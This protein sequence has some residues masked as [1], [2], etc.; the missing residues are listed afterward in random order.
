MGTA[1]EQRG[2][3][4][5]KVLIQTVA[6][7]V[8]S[9]ARC[10]RKTGYNWTALASAW[11]N[12]RDAAPVQTTTSHAKHNAC[13]IDVHNGLIAKE[14]EGMGKRVLVT[15]GAGFVGSHLCERLLG[16]GHTV[17]CL[18]NYFTGTHHIAHLLTVHRF[19]AIR[20]D[21]TVTLNMEVDEIYNLACP[22]SPVHYQLDPV[23]TTRTN[24]LGAINMLELARRRQDPAGVDQRGL[25]RPRSGTSRP[26]RT[27]VTS[28]P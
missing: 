28:T 25:R 2:G 13:A 17:I 9:M 15:G 18:D 26:K 4:A 10:L 5:G 27:G 19:E 14:G 16:D 22:A 12:Q 11:D 24:V 6:R 23:Q 21:V 8:Q 1:K 7:F 20:H 3:S